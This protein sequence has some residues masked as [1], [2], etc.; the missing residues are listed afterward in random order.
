MCRHCGK[1]ISVEGNVYTQEGEHLTFTEYTQGCDIECYSCNDC[2]KI[3]IFLSTKHYN[4]EGKEVNNVRGKTQNKHI[5]PVTVAP[6]KIK[7]VPAKYLS[8]YKEAASVKEISPKACALICRR[9]L[10]MVLENECGCT[11]FNL[12]EKVKEYISNTSPSEYMQKSMKY[13]VNAGNAMAHD[14]KDIN[15]NLIKLKSSD[16]DAIL[17][18]LEAVFDE[19]FVKP[20]KLERLDKNL[21]KVTP[22]K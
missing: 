12:S 18:A 4:S 13:I 3:N 5:F 7:G 10:E 20:K 22:K 6:L 15:D 9:V 14:K 19:I 8:E 17:N 11:K 21:A 2:G 16:C 1:Q